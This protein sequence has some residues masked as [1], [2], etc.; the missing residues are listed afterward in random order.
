MTLPVMRC[1][2]NSTELHLLMNKGRGLEE[3]GLLTTS[4]SSTV[5]ALL[6]PPLPA[7]P[8]ALA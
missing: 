2:Q 4:D 7:L 6:G 8:V 3:P 5:W 1:P